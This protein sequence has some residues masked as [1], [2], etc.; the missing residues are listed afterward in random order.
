MPQQDPCHMLPGS[1]GMYVG[2]SLERDNMW[3][4][5][6]DGSSSS[7]LHLTPARAMDLADAIY[8]HITLRTMQRMTEAGD[9]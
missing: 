1:P 4:T 8:D 9:E 2:Y 7:S 3:I 5:L 6:H